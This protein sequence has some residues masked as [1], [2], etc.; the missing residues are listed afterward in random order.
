MKQARLAIAAVLLLA[1]TAAQAETTFGLHLH[2]VHLDRSASTP[3]KVPQDETPGAY[4]RFANGATFGVVR[5]SFGRWSAYAAHTSD[6]FDGRAQLTLGAI[7]GYHNR[8]VTGQRACLP[9]R[10]SVPWNECYS[11]VGTTNAVLR[12]LIAPSVALPAVLGV[13]PRVALLGKGVHFSIEGSF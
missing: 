7:T 13:T 1:A 3:A 2:T 8:R 5:N 12:P 9:G 10:I 4:V 11:R 6:W